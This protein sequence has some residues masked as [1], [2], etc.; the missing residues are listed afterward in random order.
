MKIVILDRDT[1]YA[2][3]LRYFLQQAGHQVW[4]VSEAASLPEIIKRESPDCLLVER[5]IVEIEGARP[6]TAV[7]AQVQL[8]FVIPIKHGQQKLPESKAVENDEAAS[9]YSEIHRQLAETLLS[10]FRQLRRGTVSLIRVGALSL[11]LDR[12]RVLFCSKS[13]TLTPLEFKLLST[14]ALNAGYVVTYQ[15]LLEQVWGFEAD[16]AKARELVKVHINHIRQKMKT[17]AP[18]EKP[19]IHLIRGFGY[20]LNRPGKGEAEG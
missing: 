19:Y 1:S 4:A 14:L 20:M 15:E 9:V 3:G 2:R 8:P 11:N 16:E 17:A 5:E 18:E 10:K 7:E 13:L 6:F 12:K